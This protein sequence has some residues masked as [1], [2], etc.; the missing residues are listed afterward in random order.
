MSIAMDIQSRVRQRIEEIRGALR[1][2]KL[3]GGQAEQAAGVVGGLQLP[4][5]LGVG[6]APKVGG[7]QL[8]SEARRRA[9]AITARVMERK[10]GLIPAVQ[11][12]RPGE[13]LKKVLAPQGGFKSSIV[14]RGAMAVEGEPAYPADRRNISV[15]V[16]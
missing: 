8:V 15:M 2:G 11:E 1:G 10:P 7:G 13:R 5:L 3:L 4:R 6:G 14:D 9:E 16:D 12:W